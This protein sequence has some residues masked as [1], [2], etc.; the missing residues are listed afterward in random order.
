M[1][2]WHAIANEGGCMSW[3]RSVSFDPPAFPSPS[4]PRIGLTPDSGCGFQVSCLRACPLSHHRLEGTASA[5]AASLSRRDVLLW[6]AVANEGGAQVR[7]RAEARPVSF[8][9]PNPEC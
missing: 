9:P 8:D 4:K 2:P 7:E 1:L 6:R 3:T 5:P